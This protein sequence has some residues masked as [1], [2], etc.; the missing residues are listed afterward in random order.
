MWHCTDFALNVNTNLKLFNG[1]VPCGIQDK[2]VTS[3]KKISGKIQ[4]IEKIKVRTIEL[5]KKHFGFDFDQVL[6]K[7]LMRE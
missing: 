1:I 4:D 6:G 7:P 5:F 3:I 2:G